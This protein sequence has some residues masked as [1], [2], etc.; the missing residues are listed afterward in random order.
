[1]F[2][3]YS[4]NH[5]NDDYRMLNLESKRIINSRD[6]IWLG[7]NFKTWSKSKIST[8]K[9]DVVDDDDDDNFMVKPTENMVVTPE[10]SSNRQP[11]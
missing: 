10:I 1:M 4:G 5:S 6:V 7:R 9:L 8:E 2:V 11:T 3:G